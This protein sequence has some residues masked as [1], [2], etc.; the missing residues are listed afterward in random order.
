MNRLESI[1]LDVQKLLDTKFG[2]IEANVAE[3]NQVE[4]VIPTNIAEVEPMITNDTKTVISPIAMAP[5]RFKGVQPVAAA[6][7]LMTPQDLPSAAEVKERSGITDPL[8][9]PDVD[10]GLDQLLS[11]W[12]LFKKSG[13]F[14]TGTKG[15]QHPLFIK[16]A[17]LQ[18]PLILS[19][20][21]EGATTEIRQS[22]TDYMNG[23]R[24]EQGIIHENEETFEHYLRRVIRHIIDLQTR[25]RAS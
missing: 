23:W 21:F 1:L 12:A 20:R 11:E 5:S 9:D 19:G 14:G 13:I 6:A 4:A 17:T 24:Y 15:R 8:M 2:A 25:R 3:V 7:P 22:V 18:V 10:A 16:M